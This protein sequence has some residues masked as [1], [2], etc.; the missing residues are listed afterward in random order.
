MSCWLGL[1]AARC[2]LYYL[3]S[4]APLLLPYHP[5]VLFGGFF[6]YLPLHIKWKDVNEQERK[7]GGGVEERKK[8][9]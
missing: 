5:V 7:R 2:L 6:F 9:W 3:P 8:N 4:D 1:D